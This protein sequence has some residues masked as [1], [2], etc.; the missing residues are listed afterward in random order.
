[1]SFDEVMRAERG[2]RSR[3]IKASHLAAA[4]V[5]I[6]SPVAA[7]Y[8]GVFTHDS[9]KPGTTGAAGPASSDDGAFHDELVLAA[10][11]FLIVPAGRVKD[12]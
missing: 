3:L 10:D 5:A 9:S 4:G 6:D 12:A 11:Q 7:M 8:R 1:M 2:R